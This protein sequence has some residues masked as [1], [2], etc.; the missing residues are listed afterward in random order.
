MRA[1][2]SRS[3]FVAVSVLAWWTAACV[4]TAS[5]EKAAPQVVHASTE[6]A[7]DPLVERELEVLRPRIDESGRAKAL[8]FELRNRSSE[9]RSFA[10]A[11][12]WSDRKDQRVGGPQR[13]WT[14]LTLDAGASTAVSVPLPADGAESWR[15]LAIRP[16]EVR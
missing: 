3:A 15:L 6:L 9:K 2:S 4:S 7:G 14:L 8:E 13:S 11:I 16:D 1:S 5:K 10:Y 12:V